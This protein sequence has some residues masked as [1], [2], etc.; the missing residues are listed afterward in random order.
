LPGGFFPSTWSGPY[1]NIRPAVRFLRGRKGGLVLRMEKRAMKRWMTLALVG[2]TVLPALLLGTP[3]MQAQET[4]H[5]RKM[6]YLF[7]PDF[8]PAPRVRHPLPPDQVTRFWQLLDKEMKE[9]AS[10][11]LTEN[12]EEA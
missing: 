7:S 9:T 10:L 3:T 11:G 5:Q 4:Q 6:I 2:L 1:N 12:L 8:P